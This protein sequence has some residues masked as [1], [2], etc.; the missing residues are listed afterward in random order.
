MHSLL[1]VTVDVQKRVAYSATWPKQ[2][3]SFM[4]GVYKAC[5]ASPYLIHAKE[6][7]YSSSLKGRPCYVVDLEP[8]GV[9]LRDHS[10]SKPS[11][12]AQLK[13]LIK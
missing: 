6:P 7:P 8:I 10:P 4:M 3:T 2:R 12:Q 13:H 11:N 9:P 1:E 5:D